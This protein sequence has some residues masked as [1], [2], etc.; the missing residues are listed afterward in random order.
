LLKDK[1]KL[2]YMTVLSTTYGYVLQVLGAT[3]NPCRIKR[4]RRHLR[5]DLSDLRTII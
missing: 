2:P 1:W 5:R 3:H 4:T